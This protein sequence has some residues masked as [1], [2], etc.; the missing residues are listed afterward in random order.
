MPPTQLTLL[1][2]SI[3]ISY[4]RWAHHSTA[5]IY[6]GRLPEAVLLRYNK[7]Q[8]MLFGADYT[9]IAVILEMAVT[10]A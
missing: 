7:T 5:T 8:R 6:Y 1:T 2:C 3:T 9:F 10:T 4:C